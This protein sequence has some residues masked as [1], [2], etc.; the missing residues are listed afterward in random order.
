MAY[1]YFPRDENLRPLNEIEFDA[2]FL[3]V[4]NLRGV[5][6]PWGWVKDIS[7]LSFYEDKG[8]TVD[9]GIMGYTKFF[10]NKILLSPLT[11]KGLLWKNIYGIPNN[12]LSVSVVAHELTHRRQMQWLYGLAWAFL[13]IPFID[14]LMIEKWARENEAAAREQLAK[15]YDR[16]NNTQLS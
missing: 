15:I 6:L 14:G 5:D 11:V 1:F 2:L 3:G 7:G 16:F 13:N 9:T 12:E 10:S 8:M 4:S